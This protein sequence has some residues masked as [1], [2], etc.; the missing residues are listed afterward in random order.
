MIRDIIDEN[1]TVKVN[2]RE[3][4]LLKEHFGGCF[5]NEGK[6]LK[7]FSRAWKRKATT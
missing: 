1:E 6:V 7:C 5:N 3:V 2:S 4:E